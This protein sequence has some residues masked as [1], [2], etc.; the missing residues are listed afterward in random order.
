MSIKWDSVPFD[1]SK[2][3]ELKPFTATWCIK[4]IH[5]KS[6]LGLLAEE[7]RQSA[8]KPPEPYVTLEEMKKSQEKTN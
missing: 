3:G 5:P 8:E 6:F 4:K 2:C 1:R 7:A